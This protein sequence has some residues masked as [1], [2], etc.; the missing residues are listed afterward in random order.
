MLLL[1]LLLVVV[2]LV[3]VMVMVMMKMTFG[4]IITILVSRVNDRGQTVK[5]GVRVAPTISPHS[6]ARLR[7]ISP[8]LIVVLFS[9]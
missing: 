3:L 1:L 6:F 7:R 8:S 5:N 9:Y 2:V 4:K